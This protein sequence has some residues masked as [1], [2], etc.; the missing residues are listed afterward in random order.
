[1]MN[2]YCWDE[3]GFEITS[4]GQENP[5]PTREENM[6][7]EYSKLL[8]NGVV[9]LRTDRHFAL[10]TW[11]EDVVEAHNKFLKFPYYAEMVDD[12]GS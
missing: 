8:P 1:M 4:W 5:D 3:L 6:G 10:E 2:L 7:W 9:V 12:N 11:A